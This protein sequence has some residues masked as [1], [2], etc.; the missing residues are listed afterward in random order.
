MFI[1]PACVNLCAALRKWEIKHGV[2]YRQSDW[3]HASDAISYLIYRIMPRR[4]RRKRG[5]GY[6]R[7][8][9]SRS[10]RERDLDKL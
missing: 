10:D 1:D 3:A 2:P 7:I 8:Q 6:E 4:L 5:I 9:P